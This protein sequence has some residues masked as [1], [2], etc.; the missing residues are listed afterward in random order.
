M[1][2]NDTVVPD[3]EECLRKL[4]VP[5]RSKIENNQ[6]Y[7]RAMVSQ[8]LNLVYAHALETKDIRFID[9]VNYYE[10]LGFSPK[11]NTNI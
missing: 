9:C 4:M 7:D 8:L 3:M 10:E 11:R 5:L 2:K 1:L 6:I